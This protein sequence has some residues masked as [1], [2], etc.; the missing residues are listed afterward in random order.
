M[1]RTMKVKDYDQVNSLWHSIEGFAIRQYMDSK[2]AVERFLNRNPNTSMVWEE[3][4]KIIG[5]V[6]CG[7]DGRRGSLYHVC[8]DKSYR[9]RGIG[10]KMV[11][12]AIKA[13][14]REEIYK[15]SLVAFKKNQIGNSFWSDLG[16]T[17]R[18]DLNYY[19]LVILNDVITYVQ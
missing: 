12:A 9:N 13:L 7:H 15:V 5:A 14:E 10:H 19:D 1:V 3:N 2:A 11:G 17:F 4:G 8:V 6:L 18:E 16:W